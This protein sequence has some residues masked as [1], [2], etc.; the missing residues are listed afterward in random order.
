MTQLF[1]IIAGVALLDGHR[2]EWGWPALALAVGCLAGLFTP[3]S[4]RALNRRPALRKQSPR[5]PSHPSRP[6]SA[7]QPKPSQPKP[8]QPKPSQQ[9]TSRAQAPARK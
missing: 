3:A 2:P 9:K 6:L 7:S 8:S 1:V 4:L 5:P